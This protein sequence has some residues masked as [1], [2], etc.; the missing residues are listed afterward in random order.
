MTRRICALVLSLLTE[1]VGLTLVQPSATA[2]SPRP[3][4]AD[5]SGQAAITPTA[6]PGVLAGA[7]SGSGRATHLGQVSVSVTEII[8]LTSPTG[9]ISLRDG[10]MIMVAANGDELHWNYTATGTPPDAAGDVRFSGTF[11]ITGGTGRFGS[12]TGAGTFEGIGNVFTF[13][14]SFSYSGTISI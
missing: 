4:K 5:F 13:M 6:T 14:A 9:V 2:A 12:A 10:R 8:D 7:G 1:L 3:F 11:V